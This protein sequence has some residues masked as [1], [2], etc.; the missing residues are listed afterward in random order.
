MAKIPALLIEDRDSSYQ[1]PLYASKVVT[2]LETLPKS[3]RLKRIEKAGYNVFAMDADG[4]A[5]DLLTDSGTGSIS[6]KQLAA[7]MLGDEAYAGASSF[8]NLKKSINDIIGIQYVVPTHQG[9]G[10][11]KVLNSILITPAFRKEQTRLAKELTRLRLSSVRQ[12][13]N[14]ETELSKFEEIIDGRGNFVPEVYIPGNTH[15]DTTAEH[16]QFAHGR[17]VDITISEGKKSDVIHPFKGNLV[18]RKLETF[19]AGILKKFDRKDMRIHVPYVIITITC[20]SGG[21]QPVSMTNIQKVSKICKK[22]GVRLFFDAARYAENAFFIKERERGY[23]KKSI[24]EIIK[25]MFSYVDGCTMSSKKDGIVPMGG[26]IAVRDKRLYEDLANANILFEGFKT[27]GGMSGMMMEALAQGLQESADE[28]Y[29]QDR[30]GLVR[31]LGEGLKSRGIPIVEPI[32]GH[33]VFVDARKFYKGIIPKDQFP[34][35]ALT[36]Y[37]Y[38]ESGVRAVEIG[39][40][41]KGRDPI[42]G[43]NKYADMDLMRLAIPRRRYNKEH[44]VVVI[45]ALDFLYKNRKKARGLRI[46]EGSEPRVGIRHFSV[47]F[48]VV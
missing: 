38:I 10:A 45:K 40:C 44:M 14:R 18:T 48:E 34:A 43:E 19:L 3:E 13:A 8:Y 15:F 6:D 31:Y 21:G 46:V 1:S 42:T 37:L 47:R 2:R 36:A 9:R 4:I 32:G 7:M 25:E 23:T 35:Q 26:F 29:L 17:P 39:S 12:A 27:Y 22:Y 33:A 24:R 5:I 28:K 20:N 41:L 30:I 16:I 11:E